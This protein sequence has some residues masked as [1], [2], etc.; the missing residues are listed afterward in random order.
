MKIAFCVLAVFYASITASYYNQGQELKSEVVQLQARVNHMSET[1]QRLR[2]LLHKFG[3]ADDK[4]VFSKQVTVTSYTSRKRETDSTPYT[5]ANNTHVRPGGIAVSRDLLPVVG[6]F[7]SN[8]T[9]EGYGTFT[10]NDVM[11]KRFRNSVDIWCG[12][13]KA[14]KLHGRRKAIMIWQ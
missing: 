6:G 4:S 9:L 2:A 3:I 12:D 7:G 8:I 5:T 14:A 11:N 10:V 13:V 1:N